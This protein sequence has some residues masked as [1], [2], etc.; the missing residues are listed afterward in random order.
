MAS[1]FLRRIEPGDLPVQPPQLN[2]MSQ[3]KR[4]GFT[5]GLFVVVAHQIDASGY[6]P[7]WIDLEGAVVLEASH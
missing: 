5:L 2:A 1:D 7:V 3:R 6:L 4:G